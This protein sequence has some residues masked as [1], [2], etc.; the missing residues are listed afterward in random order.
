MRYIFTAWILLCAATASFA[1]RPVKSVVAHFKDMRIVYAVDQNGKRVPVVTNLDSNGK[2]MGPRVAPAS[3]WTRVYRIRHTVAG[4]R[5]VYSSSELSAD[6]PK[7]ASR[8]GI[9]IPPGRS[10][11]RAINPFRTV[12]PYTDPTAIPT[13]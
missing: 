2:P 9:P 11:L 1:D 8:H 5:M 7:T 10:P 6:N 13:H 12:N 4:P 3:N